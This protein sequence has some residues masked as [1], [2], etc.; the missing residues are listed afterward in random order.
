M[1]VSPAP[2]H[3]HAD[4]GRRAVVDTGALPWHPSPLAGVER[5]LLERDGGEECLVLDGVFED[6]QGAYPAGT[7]QRKPPGRRHVPCSG[8]GGLIW[9]KTGHLGQAISA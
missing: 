1:P 4:L 6:E 5:R 3:V 8:S 9:V 2:T 7:W